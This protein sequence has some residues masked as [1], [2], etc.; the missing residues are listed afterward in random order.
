MKIVHQVAQ[1]INLVSDNRWQR[2][3]WWLLVGPKLAL[4]VVAV[5]LGFWAE[6]E[7]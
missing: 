1:T 5:R 7:E 3:G 4:Y 6:D 2:I